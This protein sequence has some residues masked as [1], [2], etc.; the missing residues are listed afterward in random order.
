LRTTYPKL[1]PTRVVIDAEMRG[2]RTLESLDRGRSD[3][4]W[5]RRRSDE[6]ETPL[7]RAGQHAGPLLDSLALWG[8]LD[9]LPTWPA[10]L[11]YP[12]AR[13]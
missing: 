12:V 11:T 4:R 9:M 13:S 7:L 5:E 8:S 6:R 3:E 1:L 2:E 10:P